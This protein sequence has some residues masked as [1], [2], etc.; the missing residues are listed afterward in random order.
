MHN[1]RK[2]WVLRSL[3]VG[4]MLM[5]G[6]SLDASSA[7]SRNSCSSLHR[8]KSYASSD[9]QTLTCAGWFKPKKGGK[10]KKGCYKVYINAHYNDQYGYYD[11]SDYVICNPVMDQT[12]YDTNCPF[13]NSKDYVSC[14]NGYDCSQ[15]QD[16]YDLRYEHE[17]CPKPS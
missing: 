16:I 13:I 17:F 15:Q 12:N 9:D 6:G 2:T 8:V 11:H 14:Y 1:H 3:V 5:G 7:P 10:G 4:V